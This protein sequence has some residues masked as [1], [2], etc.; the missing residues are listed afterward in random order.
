MGECIFLPSQPGLVAQPTQSESTTV[1]M[2]NEGVDD[3]TVPVSGISPYTNPAL[4]HLV[5]YVRLV[6]FEGS[7]TWK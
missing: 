3:T 7:R 1:H 5:D 6:S 2:I 4:I